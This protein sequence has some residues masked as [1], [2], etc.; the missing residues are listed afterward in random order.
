[1]A[2][3]SNPTPD[4][5]EGPKPPFNRRKGDGIPLSIVARD[6]T[7]TG[8]M[9]TQG[10][11]KVEGR[12]KGTI[13]ADA[14]VIVSPGAIIEGDLHSKEAVVA[15]EVRGTINATERVELQASAL[16]KGDIST[17]RIAILEGGKVT[18]EVRMNEAE[19]REA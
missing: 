7:I 15:G 10:V 9:E 18:G 14:Q 5:P 6:M 16:V 4:T 3:F 2:I 8:D 17:P 1:M 12:V 19:G 13:R 11:V